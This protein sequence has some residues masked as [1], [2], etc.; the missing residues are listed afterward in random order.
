MPRIA[1]G[2]L[3]GFYLPDYDGG[4]VLNLLSS[5]IRSQGGR[6]PHP[7]LR[8]LPARRL[9][10]AKRIAYVVID[11][12]G[13]S[14]LLRFLAAGKGRAFF[15]AHPHQELST[16]FPATTASAV[17]TFATG[18]SPAEHG[19][20]GWFL[21]L[22]DLGIVSTILLAKTRTKASL[23]AG[24]FDLGAYLKLPS[25][26]RTVPGRREL[27]T[28]GYILTSAYSLATPGWKKRFG[29]LTLRG[30]GRQVLAFA[31]RRGRGIAY[32]Y[33]P[34]YD[35]ICHEKGCFH[36]ASAAHFDEI[37]RSLARLAA[38]IEGTGTALLV[39]ADHGLIDAPPE[40]RIDLA[41][42]PG[43][44]DCL[45]TLPAGDSRHVSCFVRPAKVREFLGIVKRHLSRACACVP[46]EA[47]LDLG[48][49]GPGKEH[50]SLRSRIGDFV[51][52]ARESC[53]FSSTVPGSKPTS[54]PGNHGGMSEE[55]VVVPLYVLNV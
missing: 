1:T 34:S 49:F 12:I 2:Q 8:G 19:V 18:A 38:G 28:Y 53:A 14:Q 4:S 16:V 36:R 50:P 44:Y 27:L 46:G 20:L 21:N 54:Y 9:R 25:H 24:P 3:A 47:L 15:A 55:E 13:R 52:M 39:F 10:K 5:I 48:A 42:V 32:A 7:E 29:Y 26:V 31:R 35:G 41:R 45:A 22:H 17:T 37:D 33:W 11:G 51:L 40:R 23:S 43:F 30:L 6:S